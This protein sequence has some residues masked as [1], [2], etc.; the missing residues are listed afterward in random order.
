[1][2]LGGCKE[3]KC[4]TKNF[5]IRF[6]LS[7]L[8]CAI[9]QN[10]KIFYMSFEFGVYDILTGVLYKSWTEVPKENIKINICLGRWGKEA[11]YTS[12]FIIAWIN[13]WKHIQ[14]WQIWINYLNFRKANIRGSSRDPYWRTA[15]AP[16]L[17]FLWE[18]G[19]F[20]D[21]TCTWISRKCL[22]QPGAAGGQCSPAPVSRSVKPQKHFPPRKQILI[23]LWKWVPTFVFHVSQWLC[24]GI[25][26]K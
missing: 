11:Y 25:G 12:F 23:M 14:N 1:M 18:L 2:I 6:T 5:I 15:I 16:E 7:L 17:A 8:G 21:S 20:K 10:T 3:S 22:L 4:H 13:W 24:R 9:E 19:A 26:S